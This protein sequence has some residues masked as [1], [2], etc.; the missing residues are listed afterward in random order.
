M[1]LVARDARWASTHELYAEAAL[2]PAQTR[3]CPGC[4]LFQT[5]PPLPKHSAARCP[6]CNTMLR[7]SGGDRSTTA[8]ALNIAAL[9]LLLLSCAVG[10]MTVS[11]AGMVHSATIFSGPEG[12]RSHGLWELAVVV[13]FTT[14]AAPLLKLGMTLYVLTSLRMGRALPSLRSAFAWVEYMRPWSMIE[15][16]LLGVAVA[17]VKLRDLVHIDIDEGLYALAALLIIMIAAESAL[18]R[19]SV[20]E[21]I[22]R[23]T[24]R[25][26]PAIRIGPGAGAV[27]R[28]AVGCLTCGLVSMPHPDAPD[29]PCCGTHL[30]RREPASISRTW[31]LTLAALVLYVPANYYP[32]LTVVQLGSGAPS[33]I[34]GGVVELVDAGAYPLAALVFFA[35][36]AVPV[37]KLIGLSTMLIT[38]QTGRVSRLRDRA[39]LY[40]IVNAIGRWSMIDIFMESILVALVQF[41]AAVTIDPGIGAVA[42]AAV[43]ILTMFAAEGF[44][45]RLM[46]DAAQGEPA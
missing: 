14:V 15:V 11:T 31:A 7:R 10:L 43:V 19:Q 1:T 18:D 26:H 39:T 6:R 4:G 16:Y 12:L 25:P 20:W 37:M 32:V 29:C 44:D 42:F 5:V 33:T 36:V 30:H 2:T 8:F 22:D 35:S 27:P 17:Y 9:C 28:G 23:L 40:R 24:A 21:E 46:W 13:V 34:L 3:E 41:G 45:P 38:T